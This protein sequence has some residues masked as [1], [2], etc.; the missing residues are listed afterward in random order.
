MSGDLVTNTKKSNQVNNLVMNGNNFSLATSVNVLTNQLIYITS[1]QISG[2]QP[3]TLSLRIKNP[4]GQII[5]RDNAFTYNAL[6]SITRISPGYGLSTGGTAMV[7]EGTGFLERAKT[8]IGD[9]AATT[10]FISSYRLEAVTPPISLGTY[11]IKVIN[12]D[13]QE[14][15]ASSAFVSVSETVYNYPNPFFSSEGTTFRYV[16]NEEVQ[17]IK[18][19]IYNLNGEPIAILSRE[20]NGEIRWQSADLN[21]GLYVYRMDVEL[22]TGQVKSFTRTLQIH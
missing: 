4:D 3:S 2:L 7:I 16:T 22:K 20:G 11:D 15:I 21:F 14:A 6:P 17:R 9:R 1:P 5:I 19:E 12:P 18:V 13:G 8:F 10:E